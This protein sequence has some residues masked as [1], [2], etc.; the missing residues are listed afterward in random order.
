MSEPSDPPELTDDDGYLE[1]DPDEPPPVELWRAVGD[2]PPWATMLVLLSWGVV[3]LLMAARHEIGDSYAYLARGASVPELDVLDVLWRSLASTF[4]HD[5]ASHV[6]MNAVALLIFG[7]AVERIFTRSG[8]AIVFAVGGV[9]AS[10][11]S[12]AWRLSRYGVGLHL[13]LG[14]SGA[15]FALGGALLGGAIRLR[16]RLAVGRARALGAAILFL[17]LTSLASGFHKLGTDNVAHAAG[18]VA[19]VLLGLT[20]PLSS[21]LADTR[22]SR[23]VRALALLAT[24]A[25]VLC[26]VR[27]LR[28][29]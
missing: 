14:G 29:S 6:A 5:G 13:A 10:L 3:F 1:P 16:H 27:V 26:F 21:R 28:G 9:L 7:P 8:F 17:A 4:L 2:V 20:L 25:L 11:A 23:I 15:V 18:L 19:G 22:P 12:V 24:L